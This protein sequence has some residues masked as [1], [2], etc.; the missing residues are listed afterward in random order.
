MFEN[1]AEVCSP[2]GG[3]GNFWKCLTLYIYIC[4]YIYIYIYIHIYSF[5]KSVVDFISNS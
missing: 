2:L 1:L 4:I 3:L 5:Y